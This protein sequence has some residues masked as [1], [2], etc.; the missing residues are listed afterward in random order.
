RPRDG[1]GGRGR[2][3]GRR[4]RDGGSRGAGSSGERGDQHDGDA[5]GEGETDPH[6]LLL[7]TE[8]R[9]TSREIRPRVRG[10]IARARYARAM[11]SADLRALLEQLV[12]IESV[13]PTLVA[14]GAGEA[15][16]GRFVAGWLEGR[17]VDVEY[18]ELAPGRANVVGRVRGSGG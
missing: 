4:Q 1:D 6:V 14:G 8:T 7:E 18:E 2:P 16:I 9:L 12:A 11:A 17:G 13:Y 15:A 10:R 3:D 5:P